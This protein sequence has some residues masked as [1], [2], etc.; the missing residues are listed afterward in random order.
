MIEPERWWILDREQANGTNEQPPDG[1]GGDEGRKRKRWHDAF[2]EALRLE[3][4]DYSDVLHF[5]SEHRLS[6]EALRMDVLVIKK[7]GDAVIDKNIGRVFRLHNVFEYKPEGDYLSI[8]DYSKVLG[9]ALIHSA[10]S[11]VHIEDIT[12]SLVATRHPRN[13]IRHLRA[14]R[15]LKVEPVSKGM[16]HVVGDIVSVQILE[17]GELPEDENMFLR[18][19]RSGLGLDDALEVIDG[20]VRLGAS[21]KSIF[22]QTIVE[23]NP[24]IFEEVYNMA[25]TAKEILMEVVDRNGWHK[26]FE[27]KRSREIAIKMLANNEHIEKIAEYTGLSLD[28]IKSLQQLAV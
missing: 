7:D 12:V 4:H 27:E 24:G 13:L 28:D 26:D 3:L 14:V 2:Y 18:S 5:E 15:G 10:F 19:L 8:F 9:Y 11:E 25:G 21:A 16:H 23:A 6:E 17:Q 20:C 1:G 22:I